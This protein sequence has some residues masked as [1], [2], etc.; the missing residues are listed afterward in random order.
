MRR[1][2]TV[3]GAAALACTLLPLGEA[4]GQAALPEAPEKALVEG[5]C[6]ACHDTGPILRSS[7]Y[8]REGWE[9]L[10]GTMIDLA[11]S[12]D[13]LGRLTG[14]LAAHFP[15]NGARTPTMVPGAVEIA[16]REWTVPTLGQRS[17]DPIQAAD[18]SIWWA[19]Q[20]ANL[21]GRIDTGTGEMTEYPL[22]PGSMPHT[23]TLD[24]AGHVWFTG[25]RNG[26][27]GRLDPATGEITV[28]K[29]PDP[30]ARDP[31]S[32]VFDADGILWFTLQGS[33][34]VGRLDPATGDVRLV[35]APRAGA[36][37]YGIKIDAAGTPWV[38]C[39]GGNCLLKVD[40]QTMEVTEIALPD[41]ATTVRRL[42]FDDQ[43]M[44][45]FVNSSQGRLGR[46]DP[47]TG[48]VKEWPSPSGP[49]SHPYAIAVA[50]GAVWYN[51]S[52]TRPDMLVRFDPAT[53]TFQSWPIPS[54]GIFAGIVR[55][56]RPTAEGGLVLHQSSTNRILLMTPGRPAK[57]S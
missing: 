35:T 26:T 31:H 13:E 55:H 47:A 25:N 56:M 5:V 19:G 34:M 17:R 28:H 9:E 21:I 41:P 50:G 43:G 52:G 23:V 22:P 48:E 36:R 38:A 44:L 24:A 11:A 51:E 7:G 29:M 30:A 42:A 18:G 1:H 16:F 37:P 15:P 8:T 57:A 32:A 4:R 46:Y 39:N 10:V 33:N 40:P 49:R 20:W 12:P 2:A 53:E 54:G 6:T 45:W 14:Y 27:V 3:V